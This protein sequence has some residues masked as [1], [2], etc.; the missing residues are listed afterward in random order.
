MLNK[1]LNSVKTQLGKNMISVILGIGLASIF[2]KACG[3]GRC[4]VFKAPSV[5]SIKNNIYE[6]ANNCYEFNERSVDC[7]QKKKNVQFA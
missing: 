4:L 2:R 5:S 7:N 6:H 1:F 3:N